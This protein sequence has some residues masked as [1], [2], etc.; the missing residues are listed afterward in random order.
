MTVGRYFVSGTNTLF[1]NRT[2]FAVA[3][4][5][6]ILVVA[7]RT[8]KGWF[9]SKRTT[10]AWL[11]KELAIV[12][13]IVNNPCFRAGITIRTQY[14]GTHRLLT[15]LVKLFRLVVV[16]SRRASYSRHL[17]FLVA[18]IPFFAI[19]NLL[20][21]TITSIR[22]INSCWSWKCCII[23]VRTLNH[24]IICSWFCTVTPTV[25]VIVY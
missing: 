19:T 10:V 4:Q 7:G 22:L 17:P 25:K 18:D 11:A 1:P 8:R 21:I 12:P 23:L 9:V 2:E 24:F 3:L 16:S 5:W 15:Y 20:C 6:S 14:T 13:L